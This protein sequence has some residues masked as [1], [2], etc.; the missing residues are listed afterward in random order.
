M[1]FLYFLLEKDIFLLYNFK[2]NRKVVGIVGNLI[3]HNTNQNKYNKRI[4]KSYGIRQFANNDY[5]EPAPRHTERLFY[6]IRVLCGV[7]DFKE[8][9]IK[10]FRTGFAYKHCPLTENSPHTHILI[11]PC[12]LHTDTIHTNTQPPSIGMELSH[13]HHHHHNIDSFIILIS[14]SCI[15]SGSR[16]IMDATVLGLG[17]LCCKW[18]I[19][20][21]Q[22]A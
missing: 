6:H 4:Y 3:N 20:H 18:R 1:I 21:H 9:K 10:I 7:Y 22:P 17:L 16:Y 8:I 2:G 19:H 5:I 14:S 15:C 11:L 12:I 13:H